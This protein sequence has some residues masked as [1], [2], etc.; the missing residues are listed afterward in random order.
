MRE[1]IQLQQSLVVLQVRAWSTEEPP[2]WEC[3]ARNT[4]SSTIWRMCSLRTQ[5]WAPKES[6]W[7]HRQP[8][9]QVN[10]NR[11]LPN[12]RKLR[13]P[14]AWS[15]YDQ[16]F[17][18]V[19][20][21]C[22][23]LHSLVNRWHAMRA[24][25]HQYH[26]VISSCTSFMNLADAATHLSISQGDL[27]FL[28]S[29]QEQEGISREPQIEGSVQFGAHHVSGGGM[30][31]GNEEVSKGGGERRVW[32]V[33]SRPPAIPKIPRKRHR[34]TRPEPS[35]PTRWIPGATIRLGHVSASINHPDST[36]IGMRSGRNA[37]RVV[38]VWCTSQRSM[39]KGNQPTWTCR[40]MFR[41]RSIASGEMCWD[42]KELTTKVVKSAIRI[43]A[44]EKSLKK[45]KGTSSAK[46]SQE[47]ASKAKQKTTPE[48]KAEGQEQ[49][50]KKV[51]SV[52]SDTEDE[53]SNVG[54]W[55]W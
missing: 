54:E 46:P 28:L 33:L 26:I 53:F 32:K 10:G 36:T 52:P 8:N 51:E 14:R 18:E 20:H 55:T 21:L 27:S 30:E 39:P 17:A 3:L 29:A 41:R 42:P 24:F 9:R 31:E 1:L 44:E 12:P 45:E 13:W 48:Q 43:V 50:K 25:L 7:H 23:F 4:S 35:D 37:R 47:T 15:Q 2:L 49:E 16:H 5:C 38:F 19:H 34:S 22:L 11:K 6:T 40:R